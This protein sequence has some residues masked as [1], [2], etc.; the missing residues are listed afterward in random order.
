M[1]LH[2]YQGKEILGRHGIPLPEARLAYFPDEAWLHSMQIGFPSVLKAQILAGGRGKAGGVRLCRS[3]DEVRR[4]AADLFG[5]SLVTKQTGTDG[6]PVRKV[7]VEKV[8]DIRRELYVSISLD[9]ERVC[10]VIVVCSEG[11]TDVE[12]IGIAQ[13]EKIRKIPINPYTGYSSFHT[14]EIMAFLDL[15]PA[16]RDRIHPLFETLYRVFMDHECLLLELNP[17]AVTADGELVPVDVKMDVDDNALFRQRNVARM[18]DLSEQDMDENEA[19]SYGLSFIKLPG[20]VGC[21]VNGAG[22]AMATMDFVKMAGGD[23]ANFLD[24]GGIATPETIAHGFR[25]LARQ[26]QIRAIFVNIFGGIVRCDKVAQGIAD[27]A[28]SLEITIP[29]IIRLSGSNVEEG[30]RLLEESGLNV[31]IVSDIGEATRTI[32][33]AI[34]AGT[35]PVQTRLPEEEER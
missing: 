35:E 31:A 24:V 32:A 3:A 22:L 6:V 10:P 19:R 7:L 13:P 2:E 20:T 9:R 12:T 25:I 29:V 11:G 18:R 15:D 17:L 34:A 21:M 23:P 30:V 33:A 16:R 8:V 28:R 5:R 26:K 1:R 27:A 4:E 14:R